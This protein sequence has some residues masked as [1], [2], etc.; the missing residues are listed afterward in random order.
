MKVGD[1]VRIPTGRGKKTCCGIL[2]EIKENRYDLRA[3]GGSAAGIRKYVVVHSKGDT[4]TA[5]V[6]NV[7]VLSESG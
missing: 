4:Y 1:Y 7:E 3:L 5:W 6:K 2:L